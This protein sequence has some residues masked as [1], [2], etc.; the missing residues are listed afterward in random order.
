MGFQ[1]P[2]N[3]K[4]YTT[5]CYP[6]AYHHH[7]TKEKNLIPFTILN[8]KNPLY[9]QSLKQIFSNFQST[10]RNNKV[11]VEMIKWQI[12]RAMLLEVMLVHDESSYGFQFYQHCDSVKTSFIGGLKSLFSKCLSAVFSM[13]SK[14]WNFNKKH[15]VSPTH[16]IERSHN[17]CIRVWDH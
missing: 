11:S 4:S 3:T 12:S 2:N 15:Y 9:E 13:K 1:V 6:T 16:G 8:K 5:I 14:M 10:S 7:Q 17:L